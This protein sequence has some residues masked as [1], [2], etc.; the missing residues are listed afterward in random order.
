MLAWTQK[1]LQQDKADWSEE[2]EPEMD[3]DGYCRTSLPVILF[4]M[5]QQTIQVLQ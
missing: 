2:T 3:V 1:S 4:Q 5:I